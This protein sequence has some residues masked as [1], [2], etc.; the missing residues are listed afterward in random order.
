MSVELSQLERAWLAAETQAD[1]ARQALRLSEELA[2]RARWKEVAKP[3][4]IGQT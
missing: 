1:E 4:W 3:E 2:I